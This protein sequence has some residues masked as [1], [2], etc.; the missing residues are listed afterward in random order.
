MEL[1]ITGKQVRVTPDI[2]KHI[3][4]RA[5]KIIKYG[6]KSPQVTLTLKVEK[7]RQIAEAHVNV[8]GFILQAEEETDDMHASVDKAMA[9]IETQ[10]RKYK[11]T[12]SHHRVRPIA[13]GEKEGEIAPKRVAIPFPKEQKRALSVVVGD[14]EKGVR[15]PTPEKIVMEVLTVEEAL[16]QMKSNKKDIFLF[17]NR[18]NRQLHLLYKKKT[19]L[20][21][22]IEPID[23]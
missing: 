22:L 2:K 7:Y 10:L 1:V 21:G 15:A 4:D 9:K 8:N 11:E 3:E 16:L 5:Q 13:G 14:R 17:R 12:A 20:I 6:L 19:G 23:A 18:S